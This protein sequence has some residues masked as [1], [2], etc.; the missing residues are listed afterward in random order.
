MLIIAK[1]LRELSFGKLMEVYRE[2]N[3]ENGQELWPDEPEGRQI[4]LAEQEFYNYLEQIFF[5]TADA[6]YLIWEEQGSYRSAL[7]LEPYEEGL[8]LEALET[9]PECRRMGYGAQLV[10]A[11][12][13]SVGGVKVYSHV[14]KR[15]T[16]S[17]RTHAK[18]GFAKSKD[19][20]VYADGSVNDRCV[21]LYY[22]HEI[23]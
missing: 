2:G 15:N 16:A 13:Q 10:Q 5:R 22:Q 3:L 6:R 11:A 19:Y 1:N 7:R 8:L 21:T 20:A 18:C 9:A 14:G 17:L 23:E 12:L 4:A